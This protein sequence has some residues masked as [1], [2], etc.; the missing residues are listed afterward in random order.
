MSEKN[1]Y[2]LNL[3]IGSKMRVFVILLL[4]VIISAAGFN[5]YTVRFSI[6]DVNLLLKEI[7]RCEVAQD[8]M[9]HD[10]VA[11]YYLL[12]EHMRVLSQGCTEITLSGEE[13]KKFHDAMEP[14]YIKYCEKYLDLV[15]QIREIG[16]E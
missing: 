7:S 11:P 9:Q 14:L 15:D 6:G 1:S 3:L 10:K 8:A 2:W 12:D 13:K 16:A 4:I 5:Y